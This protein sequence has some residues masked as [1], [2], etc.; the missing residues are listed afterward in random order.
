[1]VAPMAATCAD[2]M[3]AT[4][5]SAPTSVTMAEIC[6]VLAGPVLPRKLIRSARPTTSAWFMR[7]AVRH[8][9]IMSPDSSAVWSKAMPIFTAA[10][11]KPSS[12]SRAMPDCPPAAT[13]LAMSVAAM[14]NRSDIR[15]MS[16]P[17]SLNW[18]GVSKFTT[19]RTSAICDSKSMAARAP[20][21]NGAA[22]APPVTI[23]LQPILP[24]PVLSRF[25]RNDAMFLRTPAK[26]GDSLSTP[27]INA[28][29]WNLSAILPPQRLRYP[30][31]VHDG[32][33]KHVQRP[34]HH[35]LGI[36]LPDPRQVV[37]NGNQA[38][39]VADAGIK[40]KRATTQA[41][42]FRSAISS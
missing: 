40:K 1:M 15:P 29:S 22:M 12:S 35:L 3:P 20:A 33:H 23:S 13:I 39:N 28:L 9:A 19:L 38:V 31:A 41:A 26:V 5:P 11:A 42:W 7:N 21:M 24:R 17:I 36:G 30:L 27:V 37:G 10:S 14:G 16:S 6:L 25:L 18:P 32:L 2:D 34:L 8:L 4:S